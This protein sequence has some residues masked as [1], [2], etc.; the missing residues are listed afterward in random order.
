[1]PEPDKKSE[2]K[3][4]VVSHY[5]AAHGGGIER[6]TERMIEEISSFG[7]LHFTWIASGCDECGLSEE[8]DVIPMFTLN[9]IEFLFGIPWPIWGPNSIMR[10]KKAVKEADVVWLQDTLYMGNILAF[11]W[12]KKLKKPTVITQHIDLIPYKNPILRNLMKWADRFFTCRMLKDASQA[13]FISDRVAE[14][15]YQ[16]VP[17]LRPIQ[18]IPNGVDAYIYRP[19]TPEKR[20]WLRQQFALR[21]DQPVIL[22]VGRFVERKGLSV[23][24][25]LAK[26]LPD[27][28]FWLAGNGPVSPR[29]WNLPN[30]HD[31]R[32]RQGS[33]LT[34]LYQAADLFILPSYGEGFPL[35]IQEALATGLPV[36]CSPETAA[37]SRLAAPYLVQLEVIPTDAT[38]TAQTWAAKMRSFSSQ[39]PLKTSD[40]ALAEFAT[41][42]W[43]WP[44]IASAYADIFRALSKK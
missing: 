24:K 25:E 22:F 17:F 44:V 37:G 4:L 1:M 34:D 29:K 27:W 5:Y 11:F 9:F 16:R 30:V 35:V 20:K 26:L 36:L 14:S 3:V 39:L 7:G 28:R 19:T 40:E 38:K 12:A 2:T 23:I 18:I 43:G 6:V 41:T 21:E 10:L 8:H 33:D 32:N 31:F 15:Y 13:T 42:S